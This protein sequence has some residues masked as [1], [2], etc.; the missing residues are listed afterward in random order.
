MINEMMDEIQLSNPNMDESVRKS[1]AEREVRS[2]ILR[3]ESDAYRNSVI[4]SL[5]KQRGRSQFRD[6]I[7]SDSLRLNTL[8]QQ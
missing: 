1:T 8:G 7:L 5:P 6:S 3:K 2:T 4:P